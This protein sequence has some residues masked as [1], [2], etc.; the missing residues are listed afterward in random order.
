VVAPARTAR[1]SQVELLPVWITLMAS[2]RPVHCPETNL[3]AAANVDHSG[4]DNPDR[5]MGVAGECT[6]GRMR[7]A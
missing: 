5:L 2:E 1:G 3:P 6:V 4:L 7:N